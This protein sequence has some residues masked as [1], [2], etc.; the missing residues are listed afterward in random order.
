MPGL[1]YPDQ[2]AFVG[3]STRRLAAFCVLLWAGFGR[4]D[5]VEVMRLDG[6][7]LRGQVT[8]S[9]D[10]LRLNV[11]GGHER[12]DWVDALLIT[13]V[14]GPPPK[15]ASPPAG[16][17]LFEL[18]DGSRLLGAITEAVDQ[19]L[20]LQLVNGRSG[21]IPAAALRR[22][23]LPGFKRSAVRGAEAGPGGPDL[24]TVTGG[25]ETLILS[26]TLKS[27]DAGGV[28]FLY[29]DRERTVPWSKLAD[30]ALSRSAPAMSGFSVRARDGQAFLGG[31]LQADEQRL[32]L[33]T[34]AFGLVEL[35]WSEIEQ[36]EQQTNQVVFLSAL[37]P[38]QV[39]QESLFGKTWEIVADRTF[40]RRPIKLNGQVLG[41]GICMHA[42]AR[43]SFVLGGA[44]R[45]FSALA[46]I[47]DEM[48]ERG[49]IL[50]RVRGD[51]KVLWESDTIRGGQP[52]RDVL[53]NVENVKLLTLEVDYGDELD[54]SDQACWGLA[55]VLR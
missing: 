10:E 5:E 40:S 32:T 22:I 19:Q 15:P 33:S 30:L 9:R 25:K 34:N 23:S 7:R 37:E 48:G 39:E 43:A 31:S 4:A 54:L 18:T 41:R 27:V 53:V 11:I 29:K 13:P 44:A 49:C 46:G 55:R 28:R 20:T 21:A 6:T 16:T 45:Q 51:G 47:I 3:T 36:I 14:G 24:L 50:M 52:P 2:S 12:L 8:A 42:R 38:V 17:M 35:P 1:T 26:G